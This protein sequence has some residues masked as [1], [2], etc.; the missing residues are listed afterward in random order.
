MAFTFWVT[1]KPNKMKWVHKPARCFSD[2]RNCFINSFFLTYRLF[3]N[4]MISNILLI[5]LFYPP[6]CWFF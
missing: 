3:E 6:T 1:I 5:F 2:P 4:R